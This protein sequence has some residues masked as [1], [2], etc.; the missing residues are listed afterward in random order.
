[1]SRYI[2]L[3]Q[4]KLYVHNET[5]MVYAYLCDDPDDKSLGRFL[6]G[7]AGEDRRFH[8]GVMSNIATCELGE[9]TSEFIPPTKEGW[10]MVTNARGDVR[11]YYFTE[12]NNW[13]RG[14]KDSAPAGLVFNLDEAGYFTSW[15]PMFAPFS[16]EVGYAQADTSDKGV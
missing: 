12:D 16:M 10:Y 3:Q 14:L 15:E 1:M 7:G 2:R 8:K 9:I 11:A 6:L 4:G 13:W 5:N